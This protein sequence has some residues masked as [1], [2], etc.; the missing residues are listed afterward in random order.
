MDRETVEKL[1]THVIDSAYAV[2]VALG[3]GLLE[4]VYSLCLGQELSLRSIPF[5]REVSMDVHYKG[6]T[7]KS[8]YRLD[9][10]VGRCIIV[11]LKSVDALLPVHE[12]QLLSYLKL[13]YLPLG[14]LINFNVPRIKQGIRRFANFPRLQP[15]SSQ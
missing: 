7:C 1:C 9:L 11:E 13:T 14:L 6:I 12:A 5:E 2:H 3:P 8:A 4:S 15:S 10:L